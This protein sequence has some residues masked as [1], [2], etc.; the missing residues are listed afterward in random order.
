MNDCCA[1]WFEAS[2]AVK[3]QDPYRRL[4]VAKPTSADAI[5]CA[6]E[7]GGSLNYLSKSVFWVEW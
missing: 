7:I 4:L 3:T 2:S 6:F 1:Q 5:G